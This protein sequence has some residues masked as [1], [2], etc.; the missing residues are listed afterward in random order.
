MQVS[1]ARLLTAVAMLI[2]IGGITLLNPATALAVPNSQSDPDFVRDVDNPAR[3]PFQ[4]S[5]EMDNLGGN[6][7]ASIQVPVGVRLVIEFVSAACNLSS[8]VPL[9]S[10]RVTTN[11]DHF[12]GPITSGANFAVISQSTRMYAEPGTN[13][14]VK[15]FPTTNPATTSCKVSVSGYLIT[16]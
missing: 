15:P 16:P 11:V 9:T 2:V 6:N 14:L 8:G 1:S 7:G 4:A 3:A 5:V 12:F 10:V 13:V